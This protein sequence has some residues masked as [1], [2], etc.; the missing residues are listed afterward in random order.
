MANYMRDSNS[1]PNQV[2]K[3]DLQPMR[4]EALPS[5]L[6]FFHQDIGIQDTHASLVSTQNQIFKYRDTSGAASSI[7]GGGRIFIYLCSQ[8]IKTIDFKRS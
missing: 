5:R 3:W 1:E 6:S 8:T 4:P 7:I 2:W